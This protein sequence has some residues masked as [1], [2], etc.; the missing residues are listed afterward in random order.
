MNLKAIATALFVAATG[1]A[2]ASVA[3]LARTPS[4]VVPL[5]VPYSWTGFYVG[6]NVGYGMGST[7]N[8][9][10]VPSAG[11]E[12]K[13]PGAGS[14]S[15]GG[16]IGA[17]AGYN[18]QLGSVVLGGEV[19]FD[20]ANVSGGFHSFQVPDPGGVSADGL[21]TDLDWLASARL[22]LGYAADRALLY[23]TAGPTLG[24]VQNS[25]GPRNWALAPGYTQKDA[26]WGWTAGAGIEYAISGNISAR[27]EYRYVDLGSHDYSISLAGTGT[28]LRFKNTFSILTAGLNYRFGDP[29]P[30]ALA[31][32][33]G[34]YDWSGFYAGASA[35]YAR[36]ASLAGARVP[37]LIE[38]GG[39]GR[40]V[41]E[42]F[43]GGGQVGYNYQ[44]GSFVVGPEIDADYTSNSAVYYLELITPGVSLRGDKARTQL[45]WLASAHLRAGYALYRALFYVIGGIAAGNGENAVTV[46]PS[47]APQ[48]IYWYGNSATKVGWTAGFGLEYAVTD[49][50]STKL[51]YRHVGF[52]DHELPAMPLA[53]GNTVH[54]YFKNDADLVKLGVNYH[55]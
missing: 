18:Y 39:V 15:G 17:Q 50:L 1:A 7:T 10:W 40:Y 44:M 12:A 48:S 21:T 2:D 26:I 43:V 53:G 52:E 23:M 35:G 31:T 29:G 36:T 24:E 16:L 22:R 25:R 47:P 4:P 42:G 30:A 37:P 27:L 19:D 8:E 28:T 20:Y 41:S 33:N 49:K 54:S 32:D 51:E 5:A 46:Q 9:Q 34:P 45:H 55:F 13:L 14:F 6:A 3:D 38:D 11:L